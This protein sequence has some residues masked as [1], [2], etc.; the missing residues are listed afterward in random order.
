M[1]SQRSFQ[2]A[3]AAVASRLE[4][5]EAAVSRAAVIRASGM[6]ITAAGL[7]RARGAIAA[8]GPY[9]LGRVRPVDHEHYICIY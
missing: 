4:A 3:A 1:G 6:L 2:H 9:F 5:L 7:S 8:S